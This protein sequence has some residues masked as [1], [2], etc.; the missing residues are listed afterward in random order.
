MSKKPILV[1]MNQTGIDLTEEEIGTSEKYFTDKYNQRFR[2]R[3]L[4]KADI[5]APDDE[6]HLLSIHDLRVKY[7]HH[8]NTDPDHAEADALDALAKISK[9]A[10]KYLE[11]LGT[12]PDKFNQAN[13]ARIRR[14]MD[15]VE[16]KS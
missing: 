15:A 4:V 2:I 8:W 6:T 3:W 7:F 10:S 5:L 9:I 1:T 16:E 11:I 14:Y 12:P 13:M